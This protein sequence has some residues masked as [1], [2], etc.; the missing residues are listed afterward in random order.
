LRRIAELVG[1][2]ATYFYK[3]SNGTPWPPSKVH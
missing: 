1:R 2:P 3:G